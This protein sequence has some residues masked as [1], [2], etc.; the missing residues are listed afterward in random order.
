MSTPSKRTAATGAVSNMS[1]D[2]LAA[3][4]AALASGNSRP[5]PPTPKR[6]GVHVTHGIFIGGS[7]LD[8]DYKPTEAQLY[9]YPTQK[10]D[11]KSVGMIMNNFIE[12]RDSSNTIKFDGNIETSDANLLDKDGF[13]K[14]IHQLVEEHGQETFYYYQVKNSSGTSDILCILDNVHAVKVEDMILEHARR[15]LLK[16]IEF[17]AYD[18]IERDAIALS[19]K[20]VQSRLTAQFRDKIETKYSHLPE[21]KTVP[22]GVYLLMALE[23]C[24]ASALQDVAGAKQLYDALILDTYPGE[25]ISDFASEARQLLKILL[26]GTYAL[27]VDCGSK[28]LEKLSKTSSSFFNGEIHD[29]LRHTYKFEAPFDLGDPKAITKEPDYA[30]KYGPFALIGNVSLQYGRL[31]AKSQWPAL[32]TAIQQANNATQEIKSSDNDDAKRTISDDTDPRECYVC[33]EVGHL[34]KDC[35]TKR[36]RRQLPKDGKSEE[37][38]TNKRRPRKPLAAW[39]YIEPKDPSVAFV[40]DD[41]KEWK[42]CSKCVCKASGKQGFYTLSHFTDEHKTDFKPKP[43]ANLSGITAETDPNVQIPSLPPEVTSSESDVTDL[44]DPDRLIF[45]GAWCAIAEEDSETQSVVSPILPSDPRKRTPDTYDTGVWCAMVSDLSLS[46]QA[47]MAIVSDSSTTDESLPGLLVR[48]DG[49]VLSDSSSSG[50]YSAVVTLRPHGRAPCPPVFVSSDDDLSVISALSGDDSVSL[51]EPTLPPFRRRFIAA[52][53]EPEPSNEATDHRTNIASLL[54]KQAT[55]VSLDNSSTQSSSGTVLGIVETVPDPTNDGT[56]TISVFSNAIEMFP[57]P[58]DVDA[59]LSFVDSIDD[60]SICDI[61][62][63]IE[64]ATV[65]IEPVEIFKNCLESTNDLSNP[66]TLSYEVL[67][68]LESY[69]DVFEDTYEQHPTGLVAKGFTFYDPE[70][71]SLST[72][73]MRIFGPRTSLIASAFLWFWVQLKLPLFWVTTLFFDALDVWLVPDDS[74]LLPKANKKKKK[75]ISRFWQ[76]AKKR[77]KIALTFVPICW[78][79]LSNVVTVPNGPPVSSVVQSTQPTLP[80]VLWQHGLEA[81]ERVK[82]IDDMVELTPGVLLQYGNLKLRNT[83]ESHASQQHRLKAL[84]GILDSTELDTYFDTYEQ[85]PL[86]ADQHH[87][88]DAEDEYCPS[89]SPDWFGTNDLVRDRRYID[90]SFESFEELYDQHVERQSIFTAATHRVL[91]GTT[92]KLLSPWAF[93]SMH[94]TGA[95]VIMDTGASLSISFDENDFDEPP[96]PTPCPL[97][98]GGMANGLSI[99]GIG[100]VTWVFLAK[101]GDEVAITTNCYYVPEAKA[102]LLSPQRLFNRSE[103]VVGYYQGDELAFELQLNDLPA[104][105]IPYDRHSHLPIASAIPHSTRSE[106]NLAICNEDNQNLSAGK[107]LMLLWHSKFGHM[108]FARVQHVLR[109]APFVAT[110]FKAASTCDASE[111]KCAICE[112]AKAK[113][114]PTRGGKHSTNPTRDGSLISGDLT[115]GASVSADHFESRLRGRT[116]DSFGK[117]TSDQSVGGCIFVDHASG[118][119]YV[120]HQLG[121]SAVETIRA[122]Q[123]F[124][125]FAIDAGVIIQSY[126]TDNGAFKAN[127]FVQHIRDHQQRLRFCG[128]NAH[129]QNGVAERAIQSVSN[130]ARAL[131]LH[132]STHWKNGIDSS[133][134]PMAVDYA[135]HIYNTTPNLKGI[136]PADIFTGSTVPRHRLLDLHVWGCPVYILDPKLQQGKK[137][138]RWEP[139]SCCGIFVGLSK[140]HSSEVPLVLNL[141]TG[142]ITPQFHVVFDDLFSTVPSIAREEEPPSNWEDLCLESTVFIPTDSPRPLMEDWLSPDEK[143]Q[144]ARES[145]RKEAIRVTFESTTGPTQP[146]ERLSSPPPQGSEGATSFASEGASTT[147]PTGSVPV[148]PPPSIPVPPVPPPPA[149]PRPAPCGQSSGSTAPTNPTPRRSPKATKSSPAPPPVEPRRSGRSNKGRNTWYSDDVYI[150]LTRV[151]SLED[152]FEGHNLQLAYLAEIH[153]CLRSGLVDI[154]DPRVYATKKGTDPDMPTFHQAMNGTKAEQYVEAMKE[155]VTGLIR[156]RTWKYIDH[157]KAMNVI[158]STWAFKL[159]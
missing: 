14:S 12:A 23:T 86:P 102:R 31:V 30:A 98:L 128:T 62:F 75:K 72:A 5:K 19:R 38:D 78:M 112:Q 41:G 27:G 113:R 11:G 21:F 65:G 144:R 97:R 103:G 51:T 59:D 71:S 157:T 88:F 154:S 26:N 35:P 29:L 126:L 7:A 134:W 141:Q 63:G 101:N 36:G 143:T 155:E 74:L 133:L 150:N 108:N 46:P 15:N 136:C 45:T 53:E 2:D 139:R 49:H 85:D 32:S 145:H 18:D 149:S 90:C 8:K 77:T 121:F 109:Y 76:R 25:N 66:A 37:D 104:I 69:E 158:K 80:P 44:L 3:L 81:Y 64:P 111:V 73:A 20:L 148:P 58:Y 16:S 153:T 89:D 83:L 55:I 119:M 70:N 67:A 87:F 122:K 9:H 94:G 1:S 130:M 99:S 52:R 135:T 60:P 92:S 28:F 96:V 118:F 93:L 114:R 107:K 54:A 95:P 156:Q 146:R 147:L 106:V 47:N 17:D 100:K 68:D 142:S 137:L 24:N 33:H 120:E 124:E 152:D 91:H 84:S 125:Q 40:D 117:P 140:V 79:V 6:G 123:S 34:A 131:I 48:P 56:D 129:H 82:R 159:K 22:G 50:S 10:R 116:Y 57:S 61:A 132:S 110:R 13:I 151:I 115:P 39:K 42:Y 127:K 105:S 4:I 43:Q 138:P